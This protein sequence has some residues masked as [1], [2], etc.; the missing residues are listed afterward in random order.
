MSGYLQ[1]HSET[2]TVKRQNKIDLHV[3][4][5]LVTDYS[6]IAHVRRNI[7]REKSDAISSKR[8]FIRESRTLSNNFDPRCL[9]S[10]TVLSAT[11][12]GGMIMDHY[13]SV[14]E[15]KKKN[16]SLGHKVNFITEC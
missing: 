4:T 3:E 9:T 8:L 12:R 10:P 16:I 11:T 14:H 7:H 5:T 15:F 1:L 2:F 6:H 13:P